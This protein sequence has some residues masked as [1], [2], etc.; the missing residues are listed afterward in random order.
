M[1]EVKFGKGN[2]G[3]GGSSNN[4]NVFSNVKVKPLG[5]G[6]KP[7]RNVTNMSS[8]QMN[9]SVNPSDTSATKR[10]RK[11]LKE[12]KEDASNRDKKRAKTTM[13]WL[14]NFTA[15]IPFFSQQQSSHN[16]STTTTTTTFS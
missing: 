12:E 15:H 14:E 7:L 1:T 4:L 3:V 2:E 13:S 9:V 16:Q 11:S 10:S 8:N 5:D 6:R